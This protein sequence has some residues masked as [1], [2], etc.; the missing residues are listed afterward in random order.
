MKSPRARTASTRANPQAELPNSPAF[1]AG[2]ATARRRRLLPLCLHLHRE[3]GSQN[4]A[5]SNVNL[6]PGLIGKLAGVGECPDARWPPRPPRPASRAVQALLPG[7][8][9][10]RLRRE[11]RRRRPRP[12]LRHRQRL[13]RRPLQ[14]RPAERRDRHPGG[15]RPLRPRHGGGPRRPADRPRNGPGLGQER[16]DPDRACRASSSTSA[17]STSTSTATSSR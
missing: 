6:P 8:H 2:T 5:A 12:L 13:P 7:L 15:G 11:R 3:D 9:S 17:R 16:P 14:R 1:E 4:F 10:P